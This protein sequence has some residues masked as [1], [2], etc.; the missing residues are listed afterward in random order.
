M[1]V[2]ARGVTNCSSGMGSGSSPA[3]VSQS[4]IPVTMSAPSTSSAASSI[5]TTRMLRD[6]SMEIHEKKELELMGRPKPAKSE[7]PC[8]K[9]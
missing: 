4:S 7:A 2:L 1:P 6:F 8:S 3:T 5:G 9:P